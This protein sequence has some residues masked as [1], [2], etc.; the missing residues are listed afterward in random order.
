MVQGRKAVDYYQLFDIPRSAGLEEIEDKYH[1][2]A[3]KYHPDRARSPD[4]HE[5]FI[6]IKEAYETLKD[7]QKR[8]AYDMSL[9]PEEKVTELS[10]APESQSNSQGTDQN[11]QV[12]EIPDLPSGSKSPFRTTTIS[13]VSFKSG[14]DPLSVGQSTSSSESDTVD[15]SKYVYSGKSQD[16]EDEG[17]SGKSG[18]NANWSSVKVRYEGL[19]EEVDGTRR[20]K[21]SSMSSF[22]LKTF[23]FALVMI[24]LLATIAVVSP[25]QLEAIGL[26]SVVNFFDKLF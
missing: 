5:K 3:K 17:S 16:M 6:K 1:Y 4:A 24:C 25:G 22:L 15:W 8:K 14:S 10:S 2:F 12:P 21:H 9:P 19:V 13:Y 7:P 18:S 26:E 11:P 20:K 23:V